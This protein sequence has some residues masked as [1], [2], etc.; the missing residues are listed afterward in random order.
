MVSRATIHDHDLGRLT[1]RASGILATLVTQYIE[2]GEPVSSLWLAQ[3]GDVGLSSASVRNVMAELEQAGYIWQ[4]HTS[5]G[6]VPT[7]RGYRY[8]VDRLLSRR[9]DAASH[10]TS[11]RGCDRPAL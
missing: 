6:R 10:R 11:R 3:H 7:D 8:F 2:E 9:R 1:Q 5:A 4:P